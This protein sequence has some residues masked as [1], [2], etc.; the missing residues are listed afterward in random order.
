MATDTLEFWHPSADERLAVDYF[1]WGSV[2]PGSSADRTF[3]VRNSSINYTA[4]GVVISLEQLG[5]YTPARPVNVQHFM[6]LNGRQFAATVALGDLGPRAVSQLVTLRRVTSRDA[7][8]GP[9]EFQLSAQ[10]TD[11]S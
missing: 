5:I 1:D 11:W 7:D 9:G 3:R 6:S 4:L 2:A 8:V 10:P